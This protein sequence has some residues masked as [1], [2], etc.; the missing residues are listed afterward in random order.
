MRSSCSYILGMYEASVE[1]LLIGSQVVKVA[2]SA[3]RKTF[4]AW[5]GVGGTAVGG[6]VGGTLVGGTAD[7]C[8]TVATDCDVGAVVTAGVVV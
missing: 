5:V 6:V 7:G 3:I 1:K 4:G 2:V 8:A